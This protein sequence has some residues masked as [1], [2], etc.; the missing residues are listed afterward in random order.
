MFALIYLVLVFILG[1]SLCRRFFTFVSVPHRIASAFLAG[2]LISTWWTYLCGLLFYWTSSPLL[3]GNLLFFVTSIALIYWL[4]TRPPNDVLLT[5]ADRSQTEFRK[6]DWIAF[7]AC[8]LLGCYLMFTTFGMKDG[9]MMIGIHQSSDFGSTL[10]IMQSFAR[11][12][13]FPT[14]FPHFSGDRMRYHFLFYF[15]AGNLEYLGFSPA[16]ANN[17]LAVLSLGS[18]FIFVMTLGALIFGSRVVGRIAAALFFFFGTLSFYTFFKSLGWDVSAIISKVLS[19]PDFIASGYE[20]RGETWGVWSLVNYANQRHLASSIGVFLLVLTFLIMRYKTAEAKAAEI[21]A[22][23][24]EQRRLEE[25]A[26]LEAERRKA[27]RLENERLEAEKR[28]AEALALQL[29]TDSTPDE[30]KAESMSDTVN[31]SQ[32]NAPIS[33]FESEAQQMPIVPEDIASTGD[34]LLELESEPKN[35]AAVTHDVTAHEN[36]S[37]ASNV[38]EIDSDGQPLSSEDTQRSE[39]DDDEFPSEYQPVELNVVPEVPAKPVK[40]PKTFGEW[41]GE[42]TEGILSFMFAGALLGLMPM[43]NGAIFVAAFAVLVPLFLMFPQRRQMV[44]MGIAAAILSLPQIIFL[45]TGGMPD[46]G[47]QTVHWGYTLINPTVM[48]VVNYLSFTFGF[49]WLLIGIA[50][51]AVASLKH[52][53]N[54]ALSLGLIAFTIG[55]QY[56][57]ESLT[58][59]HS[60]YFI[61][62]VGFNYFVLIAAAILTGATF[63]YRIMLATF[64]LIILTFCFQF[65]LEAMTN[66]KFLNLWVVLANIYVGAGVWFLWNLKSVVGK[67]AGR[68]LAVILVILVTLSGALDL[69]PFHTTDWG[70]T[71][72]RD[73]P[74]TNWVAQNTPP[75]AVFLSARYTGHPILNAGRH[76]FY[77]HPYYAWGAGYD[78]HQRDIVYVRML[79]STNPQEVFDMLKENGIDYV[80]IDNNLRK[81]NESIKKL[82]EAIYEAYF[83]VVFDDKEGKYGKMVI[84]KVP[85]VLGAPKPE[86][87]LPPEE[88]RAP[89]NPNEA[90]SAFTGGEGNTPGKF[91][92]PRGIATDDKGN[93]YVADTGNDRIQKFDA[94]GKFVTLFGDP[95]EREGKLKEPNGVVVDSDGS[96]YVT[97]A[98]NMKLLKYRADGTFA[99]EYFGPDS[100]FYGPRDAAIDADKQVYVVDQGRT[101]IAKFNPQTEGFPVIWGTNGTGDGELKDPTGV[102]VGDNLV[103]VADLG[104]GR[105]QVFDP[106]GKYI[107]QWDMPGWERSSS[108]FPDIAYDTVTKTVYV[109]VPKTNEVLAFDVNGAPQKGFNSQGDERMENPGSLVILE[110]NK[111][112]WLLV[113]NS[114]SNRVSKFELEAAKTTK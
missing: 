95:G 72:Y 71:P 68:S 24:A 63:Q 73:D 61:L 82:N 50:L 66:H 28:A 102:A 58:T 110:A 31:G 93:F 17:I 97:D 94:N 88:P 32:L 79:E 1:D 113:V 92:K 64:S 111:K 70:E 57:L 49:K 6:W 7:G 91:S 75:N 90:V 43:W 8:F 2:V 15:Q 35:Q 52:K 62:G 67:M 44:G 101:R 103:F 81:N 42:G 109:T 54:W 45:K 33:P 39:V 26:R 83:D 85:D 40:P 11:G 47:Y 20:Y 14:E 30:G 59:Q 74:L 86:V 98:H 37:T 38:L 104:N 4:R 53:L 77:G 56:A 84:Y 10:S 99:K 41:L 3:W 25:Q 87:Q 108:E 107:R 69:Y 23:E 60:F 55:F 48:Q 96:V 29:E 106:Q 114:G 9:S 22:Y 100:G 27:Q 89:I 12:H 105:I 16:F 18:M 51:I 65:S 34:D 76:L 5:H 21:K 13:N 78:T 36:F 112:R 19:S 46:P 80:A